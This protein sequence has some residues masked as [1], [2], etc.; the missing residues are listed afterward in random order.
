MQSSSYKQIIKS[1]GITGLAQGIDIFSRL[2]RTK[3]VALWLG[4]SGI[5]VMGILQSTIEL[6]SSFSGLGLGS[7]AIRSVAVS[8]ANGNEQKVGEVIT[9]LRWLVWVTGVFGMAFCFLFAGSLSHWAFGNDD[10]VIHF[11][12]LSATILLSQISVGQRAIIQGYRRLKWLAQIQVGVGLVSV[13]L[14]IP[15]TYWLRENAIIPLIAITYVVTLGFTFF[16]A[17]KI[18]LSKGTL[19]LD[20]GKKH[21]IEM[22]SLGFSTMLSG[23]FVTAGLYG[24]R[25][26]VSN[27]LGIVSA[28]IYQAGWAFSMLYLQMLFQAMSKDYF[29][30]LS[31]LVKDHKAMVALCNQQLHIAIL[32]G[33]PLIIFM[34]CFADLLIPLLYSSEF[35]P[36]IPLFQ[37]LAFGTLLKLFVW[38]LAFVL[39]AKKQSVTYLITE[40]CAGLGGLVFACFL[41]GDYGLKGV[42][43]AYFLNYVVYNIIIY[44]IVNRSIQ[45]QFDLLSV[46]LIVSSIVITSLFLMAMNLEI[47][48]WVYWVMKLIFLTFSVVFSLF[49]FNKIINLKEKLNQVVGRFKK[50]D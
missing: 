20:E 16:Y 42:G 17:R 28:G 10:Y 40:A 14:A 41:L 5:G 15:I 47:N 46:K 13:L 29:P 37:W 9:T 48:P 26:L 38:P 24:V 6:I 1:S 11:Q 21:S 44:F 31:G 22:I 19:T 27:Q 7:S 36:A 34:I 33:F 50:K 4:A 12:A 8:V 3:L 30:H 43:I 23:L 2:L 45:F 25:L 39:L 18:P 35:L 32:V 49:E